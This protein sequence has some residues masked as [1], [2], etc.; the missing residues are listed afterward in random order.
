MQRESDLH[1]LIGLIYEAAVDPARWNDVLRGIGHH[2]SCGQVAVVNHD[3]REEKASFAH[4]FGFDDATMQEYGETWAPHDPGAQ[5]LYTMPTGV[6][7]ATNFH[8]PNRNWRRTEYFNEFAKKHDIYFQMGIVLAQDPQRN[9]FLGCERDRFEG[10]WGQEQIQVLHL[11]G[12]HLKRSFQIGRQFSALREQSIGLASALDRARIGIVFFD[13]SGSVVYINPRAAECLSGAGPLTLAAGRLSASDAAAGARLLRLIHAAAATGRAA[14]SH[15]GGFVAFPA[16][17]PRRR[18]FAHVFPFYSPSASSTFGNR[19]VCAVAFLAR[20]GD[21]A[22]PP[23]EFLCG[24]YRL[25][26]AEARLALA[27]A[28]GRTLDDIAARQNLSKETLRT[29]LKV[30]FSKTG[31]RRQAELV[32]L[33]MRAPA[34]A[35][36]GGADPA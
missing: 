22:P 13:E 23:A 4:S 12:P 27:L 8:Y 35:T 36:S 20:E 15:S 24:V 18:L 34:A 26:P 17:P 7:T 9:S 31:A 10:E 30:V 14:G 2:V 3:L 6:A 25:T 29:Q 1:A 16:E 32:R 21:V 28:E 5:V 11:L 33:V 19:R